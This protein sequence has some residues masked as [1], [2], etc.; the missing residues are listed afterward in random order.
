MSARDEEGRTEDEELLTLNDDSKQL[1]DGT[2]TSI[3]GT[4]VR[5][6]EKH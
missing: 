4:T 2:P 5:D 3:Q 1:V 6:K